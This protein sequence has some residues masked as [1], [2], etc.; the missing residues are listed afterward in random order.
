MKRIQITALIFALLTAASTAFAQEGN[1][2]SGGGNGSKSTPEDVIRIL[3]GDGT[4]VWNG[5][6]FE[7]VVQK[8]HL[9]L[10]EIYEGLGEH[11]T[12]PIRDPKAA[13]ILRKIISQPTLIW[14]RVEGWPVL[15]EMSRV[16]MEKNE[17]GPCLDSGEKKDASVRVEQ[18]PTGPIAHVCM[19]VPLLTRF[20][21]EVLE[22]EIAALIL[23]ELAH[24]AGYG[25][26]EADF[27]QQY[28]LRFLTEKC[29]I[30]VLLAGEWRG[31]LGSFEIETNA[32]RNANAKF[33]QCRK[34]GKPSW[35][36]CNFATTN[37]HQ[38]PGDFR[39]DWTPGGP[40][41]LTFLAMSNNGS[42]NAQYVE[43][44]KSREDGAWY[45]NPQ[46]SFGKTRAK[47]VANGKRLI[48]DKV[49]IFPGCAR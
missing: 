17:H 41:K 10:V 33:S 36:A 26:E 47:L 18:T 12:V 31:G 25:E 32:Y 42:Y 2:G 38:E 37:T 8:A 29:K 20:P 43:W 35:N 39:L 28:G 49:A 9:L 48:L 1:E 15:L 11:Y 44:E 16:K 21:K 23:H 27:I 40:G 14:R 19:S 22:Q 5:K 34:S 3:D 45:G 7:A 24:A 46:V 30:A 6:E 13:P 4:K